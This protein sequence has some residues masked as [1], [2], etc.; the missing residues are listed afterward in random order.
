MQVANHLVQLDIAQVADDAHIVFGICR[1]NF[2]QRLGATVVQVR[3]RLPKAFQGRRVDAGQRPTEARAR[4]RQNGA[5]VVQASR[6]RAVSEVR[7][8]MTGR[9]RGLF[10]YFTAQKRVFGEAAVGIAERA[11]RHLIES[12]KVGRQCVEVLAQACGWRPESLEYT[13]WV[14][15]RDVLG[16]GHEARTAEAVA[17]VALEVLDLVHVAAPVHAALA[18]TARAEQG[19]GVA[20]P[21]ATVGKVPDPTVADATKMARGACPIAGVTHARVEGVEKHLFAAQHVGG[22]RFGVD[23]ADLC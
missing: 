22:Q 18:R 3:R 21:F 19:L 1:E 20:E 16:I 10:V 15:V 12:R 13:R 8:R 23:G 17:N 6:H 4:G 9:T 2:E 14:F 7:P 11:A 5:D